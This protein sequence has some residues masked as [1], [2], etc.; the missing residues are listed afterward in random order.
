MIKI[1]IVDDHPVVRRGLKQIINSEPDMAVVGEADNAA[2]AF[3]VI[4]GAACDVVILDITLPDTNGIDILRQLKH[5]YPDMPVLILSV[6]PEDQYALR[7]IKAGA[8][9]YLTKD[10]APESLIEAIKRVLSGR[11]YVS[12]SLAE[13]LVTGL[14][15]QEKALHE[16]L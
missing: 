14:T 7:V 2:K 16:Q 3:Q 4:H 15:Y 13:K 1:V 10:S 5:E 12:P 6:H 11:K 8:S 9:G